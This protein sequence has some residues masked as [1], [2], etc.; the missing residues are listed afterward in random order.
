M[1][2]RPS[3]QPAQTVGRRFCEAE[4][5]SYLRIEERVPKRGTR[6]ALISTRTWVPNPPQN[7]FEWP[8]PAATLLFCTTSARSRRRAESMLRQRGTG[9]AAS[10][11]PP[12]QTKSSPVFP[13]VGQLLQRHARHITSN[14]RSSRWSTV[15]RVEERC[16]RGG[17]VLARTPSGRGSFS[18]LPEKVGGPASGG[19]A[20]CAHEA[21]DSLERP[22][23]RGFDTRESLDDGDGNSPPRVPQVRSLRPRSTS[24]RRRHC[25]PTRILLRRVQV[26]FSAIR[27]DLPA[28]DAARELPNL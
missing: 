1:S 25:R 15:R 17:G 21:M 7:W 3:P 26:A 2:T 12:R 18:G 27:W 16:A 8:F 13:V 23:T 22:R 28:E 19:S 14:G 10:C 20:S 11:R 9:V 4:L 24:R 6:R 5:A